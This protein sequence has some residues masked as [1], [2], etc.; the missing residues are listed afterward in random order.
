MIMK[1]FGGCDQNAYDD[2]ACH[3]SEP[4]DDQVIP[5]LLPGDHLEPP[6][7]RTRSYRPAG[8][9]PE[10]PA[11]AARTRPNAESPPPAPREGPAGRAGRPAGP[12]AGPGPWGPRRGAPSCSPPDPPATTYLLHIRC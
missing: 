7:T 2:S 5:F 4:D 12:E 11:R 9:A 6:P 10:R 1:F 3:S 8:P